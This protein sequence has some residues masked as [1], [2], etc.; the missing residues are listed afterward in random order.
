MRK[1]KKIL[2]AILTVLT[3]VCWVF[4]VA[5]DKKENQSGTS[6]SMTFKTLSVERTN[7]YGEVSNATETFSFINEVAVQGDAKFIVALDVYGIEQVTTKTIALSV[8]DNKV[9]VIEMIADEPKSV[10]EVVIR[11][12]AM[13]EVVFATS[14]GTEIENQMVE[15][16]GFASEPQ[17]PSRTGYTFSGWDYDFS[18]PITEN[19]TI[20]AN[21]TAKAD[22][23]YKVEY[24]LQ[25]LEN[26]GFSLLAEETENS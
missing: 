5:C 12:R 25:N 16:N 15:E 13:C 8:G 21:W 18:T 4:A 9:Y 17:Q 11:R 26:S 20:T 10:Y 3:V 1:T 2:L 7:V 14:G 23:A 6:S 19:T 22:T 24:Y